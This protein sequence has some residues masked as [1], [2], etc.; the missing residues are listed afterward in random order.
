MP[1]WLM[2]AGDSR[3]HEEAVDSGKLLHTN[4]Q[5]VNSAARWAGPIPSG[6]GGLY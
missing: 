2:F 6:V 4:G 1:V 5:P 3:G